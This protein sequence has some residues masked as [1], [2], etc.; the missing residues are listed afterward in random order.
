[1]VIIMSLYG[2]LLS[3][4]FSKTLPMNWLLNILH[5]AIVAFVLVVF[6]A[7]PIVGLAFNKIF[8]VNTKTV[9]VKK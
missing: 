4:G 1:M 2:A 6:V 8:S 3:V 7:N 5:N 9:V